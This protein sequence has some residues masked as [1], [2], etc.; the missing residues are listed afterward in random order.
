M[1]LRPLWRHPRAVVFPP[2]RYCGPVIA[3]HCRPPRFAIKQQQQASTSRTNRYIPRTGLA[4]RAG[5]LCEMH[6]KQSS[7]ETEAR[8]VIL[9]SLE[10]VFVGGKRRLAALSGPSHHPLSRAF[11]PSCNGNPLVPPPAFYVRSVL[12]AFALGHHSCFPLLTLLPAENAVC[13]RLD[14]Y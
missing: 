14:G 3:F 13:V 12:R 1:S 7:Y 2:G 10:P 8:I 6:A 9:S 5:P 11:P 4:G